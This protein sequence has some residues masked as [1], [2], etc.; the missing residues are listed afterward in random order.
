MI[1]NLSLRQMKDKNKLQKE[2]KP[3]SIWLSLNNKTSRSLSS[4]MR[5]GK[6]TMFSNSKST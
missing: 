3:K 4:L 2:I 1:L 6:N 5:K